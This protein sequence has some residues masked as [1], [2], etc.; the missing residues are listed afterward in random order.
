MRD[1]KGLMRL[2]YLAELPY[3]HVYMCLMLCL[4]WVEKSRLK[5]IKNTIT[6]WDLNWAYASKYLFNPRLSLPAAFQ[7]A[8]QVPIWCQGGSARAETC[9]KW[10]PLYFILHLHKE[11]S[12]GAAQ[13]S[14]NWDGL[15]YFQREWKLKRFATRGD[16]LG[17]SELVRMDGCKQVQVPLLWLRLVR[18]PWSCANAV[19]ELTCLAEK[20]IELC[21][22]QTKAVSRPSSLEHGQSELMSACIHPWRWGVEVVFNVTARIPL[23]YVPGLNE[24]HAYEP[25]LWICLDQSKWC[26]GCSRE[27]QL[28]AMEEKRMLEFLKCFENLG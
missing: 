11:K 21:G 6:L 26:V 27:H 14:K 23:L 28:K 10:W 8:I 4:V 15:L 17:F 20:R 24:H 18:K 2:S 3:I 13:K 22:F 9:C 16:S 19:L 12:K 5:Y 1:T 25:G 7:P